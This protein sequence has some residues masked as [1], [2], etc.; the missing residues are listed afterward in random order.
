MDVYQIKYM[1]QRFLKKMDYETTYKK[2]WEL[3]SK[4]ARKTI[5]LADCD[6]L[7][8]DETKKRDIYNEY[9]RL[10]TEIKERH[11]SDKNNNYIDRHKIGACFAGA[12][13]KI[14]P[15]IAKEK[16]EN[17]VENLIYFLPNEFLALNVSINIVYSF[18]KDT[19]LK[20]DYPSSDKQNYIH[21]ICYS[22]YDEK[23]NSKEFNSLM[24]SNILFLLEQYNIMKN[25]LEEI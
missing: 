3:I 20:F 15:I 25:K 19:S 1:I 7:L 16:K 9:E 6:L 12:V 21:W 14:K 22:L 8:F 11:F 24:F 4:C 23:L 2:I 13:L 18:N 10:K 5:E 17:E